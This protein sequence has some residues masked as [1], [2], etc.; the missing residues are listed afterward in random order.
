MPQRQE[1]RIGGALFAGPDNP[2]RYELASFRN[3]HGRLRRRHE[4]LSRLAYVYGVSDQLLQFH[5][6]CLRLVEHRPE[7]ET[8]HGTFLNAFIGLSTKVVSHAESIR[9]L[10][11]IGRYGDA[12]AITRGF[13]GD[14]TMI[15]YL[16]MYPEDCPDWV[17]LLTLRG[18]TPPRR[19]RYR[20][21]FEKFRES[22][23][24]RKMEEA[25]CRPVSAKGYGS[26]SEALHPSAWGLQFYA[27]VEPHPK[28]DHTHTFYYAPTYEPWVALREASVMTALLLE[29]IESFM[30]WC[31]KA[32]VTWHKELLARWSPIQEMAIRTCEAGMAT[33]TAM[34]EHFYRP[35]EEDSGSI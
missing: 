14:V 23:M 21:L 29:P 18:L 20:Q 31:E 30:Y 26:Y 8:R 12:A 11:G 10:M 4:R 28:A 5:L 33:A 32:G 17:E 19:G 2:K 24:R 27:H 22:T 15:R 13:I 16:S 35:R 9:S 25:G 3:L 6:E 1:R 34:F 7:E